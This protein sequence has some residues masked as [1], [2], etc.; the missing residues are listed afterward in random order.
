MT[1]KPI[2]ERFRIALSELIGMCMDAGI[3]P[4][5]MIEHLRRETESCERLADKLAGWPS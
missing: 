5:E 1:D 3:H 2:D 4:S